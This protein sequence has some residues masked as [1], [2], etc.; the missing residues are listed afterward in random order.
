MRTP[1]KIALATKLAA[2][3]TSQADLRAHDGEHKVVA[4]KPADYYKPTAM[5]DRVVLTLNGDPRTQAAV[6]WRTSTEV[7]KALA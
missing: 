2:V 4:V 3:T 7:Q 1:L 5:P 6:T